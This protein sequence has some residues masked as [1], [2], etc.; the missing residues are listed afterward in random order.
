MRQPV[1]PI[2]TTYKLPKS[3]S[4]EEQLQANQEKTRGSKGR[5]RGGIDEFERQTSK[6]DLDRVG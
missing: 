4:N 3:E 1:Q 6:G 5:I 2:E